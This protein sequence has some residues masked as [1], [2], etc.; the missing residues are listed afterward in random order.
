MFQCLD[1]PA[2]RSSLLTLLLDYLL[3]TTQQCKLDNLAYSVPVPHS[4]SWIILYR[5]HFLSF[6]LLH[7]EDRSST[8]CCPR[9]RLR[10]QAHS[11]R[12]YIISEKVTFLSDTGRIKK[13]APRTSWVLLGSLTHWTVFVANLP[14]PM[15]SLCCLRC[16]WRIWQ[17]NTRSTDPVSNGKFPVSF[18]TW[19]RP[20]IRRASRLF[21]IWTQGK[22]TLT[23]SFAG[24]RKLTGLTRRRL[25]SDWMQPLTEICRWKQWNQ[26]QDLSLNTTRVQNQSGRH[27]ESERTNWSWRMW[28]KEQCVCL[29]LKQSCLVH[30]LKTTSAGVSRW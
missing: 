17:T 7:F 8:C 3:A 5:T 30:R 19:P 14:L 1:I 12:F 9:E 6:F 21:R 28:Q 10:T 16:L 25:F 18:V 22:V 23:W 11:P 26:Y 27:L 29:H 20:F 15:L 4:T 2:E 24:Q 13:T